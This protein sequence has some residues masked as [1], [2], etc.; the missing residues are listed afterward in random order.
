M[1]RWPVLRI[2][3]SRWRR[4]AESEDHLSEYLHE[5]CYCRKGMAGRFCCG[6][7]CLAALCNLGEHC[8]CPLPVDG[9]CCKCNMTPA[10]IEQ[11]YAV[12]GVLVPA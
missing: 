10:Q 2:R 6:R 9:K 7:G 5:H 11:A 4:P 3:P 8:F 1:G 12:Y